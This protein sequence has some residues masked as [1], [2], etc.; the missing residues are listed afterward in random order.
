MVDLIVKKGLVAENGKPVNGN[1]I[2]EIAPSKIIYTGD[3]ES[4]AKQLTAWAKRAKAKFEQRSTPKK[5]TPEVT[6]EV[7]KEVTPEVKVS[8]SDPKND[9]EDDLDE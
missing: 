1:V 7:T 5:F 6:K 4:E 9:P 2:S 3:I 8:K